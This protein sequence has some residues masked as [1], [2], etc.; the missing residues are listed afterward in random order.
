[1]EEKELQTNTKQMLNVLDKEQ[2]NAT[3]QRIDRK[4]SDYL[5]KQNIQQRRQSK[6]LINQFFFSIRFQLVFSLFSFRR[7]TKGMQ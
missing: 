5:S 6:V 7:F 4:N 2:K 1:M 3:E